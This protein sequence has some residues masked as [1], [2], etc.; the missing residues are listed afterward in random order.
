MNN[1]TGG[2]GG[3]GFMGVPNPDLLV[4]LYVMLALIPPTPPPP[5]HPQPPTSQI[6]LPVSNHSALCQQEQ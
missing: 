6:I 3:V 5:P 4:F 2:I 1:H